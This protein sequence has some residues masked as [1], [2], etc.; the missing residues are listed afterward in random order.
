MAAIF[1]A[2]SAVNRIRLSAVNAG[3]Y[4]KRF[5]V[6]F[7]WMTFPPLVTASV[8]TK[9]PRFLTIRAL[10][11]FPALL[12]AGNAIFLRRGCGYRVYVLPAAVAFHG[13]DGKPDSLGDDRIFA[14][15]RAE[16]H[17]GRFLLVGHL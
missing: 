15:F 4:I 12:A 9:F 10:K 6:D 5:L 16:P 14:A 3:F 7:V 11:R 13:V 17:D 1:T 2:R 8:R